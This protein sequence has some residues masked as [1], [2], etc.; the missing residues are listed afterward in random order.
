[1]ELITIFLIAVGLNFDSLAVSISTGLIVNRIRFDQA[2][3]IALVMAFFQGSMPFIGWFLGSQIKDFIIDYDHW[4]AF[5][6]LLLIGAKMIYESLKKEEEKKQFNPLKF[7]VMIGMAIATSID[8]LIV[9]VSFAFIDINI[10]VAIIIIGSLTFLISMLGML[11]GK[12]AGGLFGKKMEIVG[13]LILILIGT[14]I[15][16][17]H[18]IV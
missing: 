2:V 3:R 16:I 10:F 4:I 9:G 13:G 15:L 14:K 6:L 5:V 17:Q 8:A 11:L 1:M 7:A 18:L 12:K